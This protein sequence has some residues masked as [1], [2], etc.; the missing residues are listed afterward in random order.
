VELGFETCG[1]ATLVAYERDIPMLVTDPWIHGSQYFGSWTLPYRFNDAQLDAFSRARYVWLSHGH[2]D[3]LNLDS[4]A[5]FRDKTLLVAQHA[6]RRIFADLQRQG[7]DVRELPSGEWVQLSDRV[8]IFSCPDWNQDT[9]VLV[10][11][12][13]TCGVLNLNDGSALG[14]RPLFVKELRRFKRRFVLKLIHYGDADM[15][16]F[17]TEDGERILPPCAEKK[18]LGFEYS[19]LLKQWD[20]TH[21]APFSCHHAY[22]RKDSQWATTIE[23][24]LADHGIGFA[25]AR[26]ELIPGFFSYDVASD[27]VTETPIERLPRE[28]RDP[29]EFGDSWSDMLEPAD[30][31]E[32]DAYFRKFD[33]LRRRFE[34]INLRVGGRDN[35]VS[36]GGPNGRGITFET[37]RGSLMTA[38]TYEIFDDLLIGNFTRTTLHG[39]VRSLY[40]DF[41]PYVA[42]YGDN[43]RAF[44]DDELREYF[45]AYNKAAGIY[46]WVERLKAASAQRARTALASNRDLYLTARRLYGH[47]K[48]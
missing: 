3:H 9:A 44:T 30:L 35:F 32:I 33:H 12:G 11:L 48:R 46:G 27:R 42:K 8:R 29:E 24:P 17:F 41:T 45:R 26:G 16:N 13:N 47:L 6:G 1:N 7:Y 22:G 38:V 34:F 39:S 28:L 15:M 25:T 2:P 40:P 21:T 5:L 18:P 37:P 19:A 4:L 10:A 43:G 14:T 20:A 23:T 31:T 36:L